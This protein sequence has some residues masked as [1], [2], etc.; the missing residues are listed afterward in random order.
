MAQW[1]MNPTSIYED[2]DSLPGLAQWVKDPA[3]PYASGATLK[4]NK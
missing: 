2:A 1:V 4:S 3:L